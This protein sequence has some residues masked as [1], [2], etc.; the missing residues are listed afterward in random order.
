M[1]RRSSSRT[2]D[3]EKQHMNWSETLD[4]LC[5]LKDIP[6][7]DTPAKDELRELV[8]TRFNSTKQKKETER[9]FGTSI[10]LIYFIERINHIFANGGKYNLFFTV[11]FTLMALS[12]YFS[13]I[14]VR[15]MIPAVFRD[16]AK[17]KIQDQLKIYFYVELSK[18]V[19]IFNGLMG[20]ERLYNLRK[21]ARTDKPN[22][23]DLF[24]Q[25][26]KIIIFQVFLEFCNFLL[27]AKISYA[28][29]GDYTGISTD[30]ML[31][32]FY[33]AQV[34]S[35]AVMISTVPSCLKLIMDYNKQNNSEDQFHEERM[36]VN[37]AATR[38]FTK[39]RFKNFGVNVVIFPLKLMV[40]LA[41]AILL[42]GSTSL[43]PTSVSKDNYF[44]NEE[45]YN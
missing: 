33:A 29:E 14:Y 6:K 35:M 13:L 18:V 7:E 1:R 30:V 9:P 16:Y 39:D 22:P 44:I 28:V 5:E 42:T 37:H 31:N 4:A 32:L 25:M 36:Q 24:D 27:Q 19:A 21:I 10:E 12:T 15:E 43:F 34:S 40:F 8:R 11:D 45:M 2:T 20:L 17:F 23:L 38:F 26:L 41:L 3:A